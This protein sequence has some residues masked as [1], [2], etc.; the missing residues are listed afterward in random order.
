MNTAPHLD[1]LIRLKN[2][3]LAGNKVVSVPTSKLIQSI[4]QLLKRFQLISDYKTDNRLTTVSLNYNQGAP[5]FTQVTIFSKPGRRWYEKAFSLPWGKS[6]SSLIIIS[7]PEGLMSQKE[8]K[9]KG[10]GGEIFAELY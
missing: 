4:C 10:L 7:T 1:F 9:V 5:A 8:A 3:Y 6:R 2:G